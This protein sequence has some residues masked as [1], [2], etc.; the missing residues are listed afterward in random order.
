MKIVAIIS[1]DFSIAQT[2][3]VFLS[4]DLVSFPLHSTY[5]VWM[6]LT[7]SDYVFGPNMEKKTSS[8]AFSAQHDQKMLCHK[9][10]VLVF[11]DL[12]FAQIYHWNQC[13]LP[14]HHNWGNA[15][16]EQ[17]DVLQQPEPSCKQTHGQGAGRAWP[18]FIHLFLLKGFRKSTLWWQKLEKWGF[19]FVTRW[20]TVFFFGTNA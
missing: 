14:A 17:K 13:V 11:T 7:V 3:H 1:G 9:D 15:S 10:F 2:F 4:K 18:F 8:K 5:L 6:F 20:F 12:T 19:I 16:S